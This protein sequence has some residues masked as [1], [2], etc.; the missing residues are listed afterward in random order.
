MLGEHLHVGEHGHEV[1]VSGPAR[2]NMEMDVVRDSRT[3]DATEVPAQV[4]A[5]WSVNGAERL[6]CGDRLA[7]DLEHLV[8]RKFGKRSD[9]APWSDH[10]VPGRVRVLVH[11]RDR[12]VA[13]VDEERI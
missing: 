12:R 11:E 5:T 1:R 9:V 2:D 6:D 4:E 7:V 10:E 13:A 3:G 8:A